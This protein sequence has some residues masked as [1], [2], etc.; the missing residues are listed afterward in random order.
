MPKQKPCR[1]KT[2][3]LPAPLTTFTFNTTSEL[4][5]LD[6]IIGQGRALKAIEFGLGITNHNYNIFVLGEG[7]TGKETTVKGIIEAKAK[8]ETV[9]DDWCCVFN[10]VEPDCPRALSCPRARV[11]N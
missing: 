5:T 10:F 9:P 11:R 3:A 2:F 1:R 7:G 8:L 6:E 4:P